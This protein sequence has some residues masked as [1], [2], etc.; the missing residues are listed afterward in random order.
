MP[1][2]E[3][4]KAVIAKWVRDSGQTISKQTPMHG[5]KEMFIKYRV[6]EF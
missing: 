2:F 5:M 1:A 6:Y 3:T 4:N